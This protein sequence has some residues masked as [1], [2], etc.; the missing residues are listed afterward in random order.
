M[1]NLSSADLYENEDTD[2]A[3]TD[4]H[5]PTKP[6]NEEDPVPKTSE[7]PV[8]QSKPAD[9]PPAPL[10]PP[11]APPAAT[12][13]LPIQSYTTPLP[14]TTPAYP[15]QGTQHIPTYQQ[16]TEYASQDVSPSQDDGNY[17]N[18]R[19]I[20]PSEMKDEGWVQLIHSLFEV[21]VKFGDVIWT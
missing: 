2:F 4:P 17:S 21:F 18:E 20:R 8:V 7:S 19:T 13:G 12:N 10:K 5:P 6:E 1:T 15:P 14:E 3:S 16:P 9:K 11:T